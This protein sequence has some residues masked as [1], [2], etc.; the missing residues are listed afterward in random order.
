MTVKS[1]KECFSVQTVLKV[2]GEADRIGTY[3][4]IVPG[5]GAESAV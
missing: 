3:E 2:W 5:T 4:S 1:R